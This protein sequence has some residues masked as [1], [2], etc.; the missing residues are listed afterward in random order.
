MSFVWGEKNVS[1]LRRRYEALTRCHLFEGM[2]FTTDP[3]TIQEW[4]PLVIE[5]R[6]LNEP[7]AA[8]RWILAPMSILGRSP[9]A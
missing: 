7:V 9:G 8:T 3:Q 2:Q 6:T 1:F 5:G 4:A